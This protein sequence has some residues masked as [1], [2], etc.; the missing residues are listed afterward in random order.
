MTFV[1][2]Y[3]ILADGR[4]L[5]TRHNWHDH[6]Y[7]DPPGYWVKLVAVYPRVK[8][9]CVERNTYQC[10]ILSSCSLSQAL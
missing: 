5:Y 6:G 8:L 9:I 2:P 4:P 7:N 3:P 10:K 1:P